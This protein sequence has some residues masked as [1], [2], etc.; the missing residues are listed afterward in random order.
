[1][2]SNRESKKQ[3]PLAVSFHLN[4]HELELGRKLGEGIY[5][6]VY[7]GVWKQHTDVA[8]KQLKFKM[9]EPF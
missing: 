2:L 1:M 8:I 9:H 4:D 6:I 7:Q 3:K 5:G